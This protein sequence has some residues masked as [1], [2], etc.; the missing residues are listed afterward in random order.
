VFP[1][2]G[3]S[4]CA[5]GTPV[6]SL[7]VYPVIALLRL[8]CSHRVSSSS[9]PCCLLAPLGL[10][11]LSRSRDLVL[12]NVLPL[13]GCFA[14]FAL[15]QVVLVY[16][17]SAFAVVVVRRLLCRVYSCV[18]MPMV[19]VRLSIVVGV[20]RSALRLFTYGL[21]AVISVSSV[22]LCCS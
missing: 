18:L 10:S 6:S 8:S 1:L 16:G 5:A 20:A 14:E 13:L 22:C 9:H 19:A 7:L 4:R 15:Q 12:A 17:W 21:P 2:V 11:R 3:R